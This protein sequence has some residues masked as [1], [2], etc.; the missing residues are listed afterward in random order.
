MAVNLNIG[1]IDNI[2]S[3]GAS[4]AATASRSNPSGDVSMRYSNE[5]MT[6]GDWQEKP[7]QTGVFVFGIHQWGSKSFKVDK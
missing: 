5:R 2:L 6:I 7:T 3:A 4:A 1:A